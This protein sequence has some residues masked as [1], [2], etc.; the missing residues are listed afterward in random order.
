MTSNY[1]TFIFYAIAFI[2]FL[3]QIILFLRGIKTK[4]YLSLNTTTQSSLS[5]SV[6]TWIISYIFAIIG[7]VILMETGKSEL[8]AFIIGITILGLTLSVL[9][10]LVFFYLQDL[11][12]ACMIQIAVCILYTW[13]MYVMFYISP[14]VGILQLPLVLRSYYTFYQSALL[15]LN[16]SSSSNLRPIKK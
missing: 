7:Y 15:Y 6:L 2:L 9:W 14:L 16:N 4:W 8:T 12:L 5:G 10:D 13:I 3:F 11:L 1:L